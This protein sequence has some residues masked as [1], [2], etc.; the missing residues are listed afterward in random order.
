MGGEG[1]EFE[2]RRA[3]VEQA[4]DTLAHRQ[5]AARGVLGDGGGATALVDAAEE[6]AQVVHLLQH[7]RGVGGELGGARVDLG[8]QG[9]HGVAPWILVRML[10]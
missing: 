6:G 2:E 4:I 3:R 10:L 8:V 7:G 1:G 5:L 9:G